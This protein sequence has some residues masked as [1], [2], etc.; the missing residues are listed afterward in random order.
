MI[1]PSE[2][3]GL[4]LSRLLIYILF[5]QQVLKI[6]VNHY[7]SCLKELLKLRKKITTT[8]QVLTHLKE[9]LQFV[10]VEN[11]DQ[12]TNLRSVEALVAQVSRIIYSQMSSGLS[13]FQH[14]RVPFC[15]LRQPNH[16]SFHFIFNLIHPFLCLS[17]LPQL[18]R[19]SY[20]GGL[21]GGEGVQLSI[22]NSN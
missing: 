10:Q 1:K 13:L 18:S 21:G 2:K 9:K 15:L 22:I 16:I 3:I 20:P 5:W 14:T 11:G 6:T 8:V 12:R 17:F 19:E 4:N 7:L